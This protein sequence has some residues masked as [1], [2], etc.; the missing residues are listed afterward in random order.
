MDLSNKKAVALMLKWCN[1][2]KGYR[3]TEQEGGGSD[4]FVHISEVEKAGLRTLND[5]QSVGY[6]VEDNKGKSSA[7][8]LKVL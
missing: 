4:V 5:N 6:E 8:Q 7:I 3:F 2:T 1:S